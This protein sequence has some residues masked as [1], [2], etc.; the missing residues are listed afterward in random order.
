MY[1]VKVDSLGYKEWEKVYAYGS[2]NAGYG[3]NNTY[4]DGYIIAGYTKFLNQSYNIWLLKTDNRGDTLWTKVIGG[5]FN[6]AAF[7]V[8]EIYDNGFAIAGYTYSYSM[9]PGS[10]KD[11]WLVKTDSLGN[12]LW[13]GVYQ[14]NYNQGGAFYSVQNT[15]DGGYILGGCE[16]ANQWDGW[17]LKTDQSGNKLWSESWGDI[18]KPG[19]DHILCAQPTNDGGF[20]GFGASYTYTDP[21]YDA[22]IIKVDSLPLSIEEN[23]NI[24]IP[25][26]L[27]TLSIK[28]NPV[29]SR[30]IIHFSVPFIQNVY[31]DLFDITGRNIKRIF[32]GSVYGS[33]IISFNA[34]DINSGIYTLRLYSNSNNIT[35][36]IVILCK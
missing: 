12:T 8:I 10:Q 4:D 23:V 30:G 7:D 33:N 20:V 34:N 36:K 15:S 1:L 31:I 5:S 6:D 26:S 18:T 17:M 24:Q 27:C 35:K 32:E 19:W 25:D 2:I 22:W 3:I 14:G 11:G 29:I 16:D 21:S 28:Q 13:S 9:N